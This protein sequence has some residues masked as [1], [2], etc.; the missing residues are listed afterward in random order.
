MI[1]AA[2]SI[3]AAYAVL[4][5]CCMRERTA[6]A[7]RSAAVRSMSPD[8]VTS[9]PQMFSLH[10]VFSIPCAFL[11]AWRACFRRSG[12]ISCLYYIAFQTKKK[13]KTGKFAPQ[14]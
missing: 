5:T 2:F 14:P 4:S 13:E 3:D 7:I 9:T 10:L 11:S 6:S 8:T 12:R 1:T